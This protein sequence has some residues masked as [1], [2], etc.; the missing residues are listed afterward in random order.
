MSN[1]HSSAFD[2][3]VITL[4]REGKVRN[5]QQRQAE[6]RIEVLEQGVNL[7]LV[8]IPGGRFP[9]GSPD[10]EGNNSERP[11][12]LVT[13]Q[14]FWMSKHP[15]THAQWRAVAAFPRV[16]I[17]LNPAPAKYQRPDQPVERVTWYDGVEFC[18]RL[19]QQTGFE[20]RLPSEAEW[21]YACRADTTTPF[22][23][24]P[25][26]PADLANY[27]YHY[28]GPTE[29]GKFRAA[30]AF[31]LYDMHGNVWEWCLDHWHENYQDAPINGSAWVIGG[32]DR[33]R[34]RRGGSWA[35]NSEN[36][37]SASRSRSLPNFKFLNIGLRVVRPSV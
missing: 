16:E 8:M 1:A 19:S 27:N 3:E 6:Q 24:G 36:C 17:D 22:H 10:D 26:L 2:Y 29:V 18:D 23:F 7:E 25:T 35:I 32:D 15:I 5:R 30:N 4:D 21:E 12:H 37:R 20:Y 34:L 28:R 33:Y 9:M 11:Q 14:S 31:G 13:V